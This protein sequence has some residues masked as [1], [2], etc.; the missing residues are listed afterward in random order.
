MRARVLLPLILSCFLSMAALRLRAQEKPLTVGPAVLTFPQIAA[1]LAAP[2]RAI[3]CATALRQRAAFVRLHDRDWSTARRLLESALDVRFREKPEAKGVWLLEADPEVTEREKVWRDRL[4]TIL[5]E[6]M[7][8]KTERVA[9]LLRTPYHV[10]FQR[11]LQLS[12]EIEAREKQNRDTNDPQI[13]QLKAEAERLQEFAMPTA[14]VNAVTLRNT[15]QPDV[16]RV[17]DTP[18]GYSP[19][20]ARRFMD[21]S[22]VVRTLD[23]ALEHEEA[24]RQ[25][26]ARRQEAETG[27]VQVSGF[28]EGFNRQFREILKEV[29]GGNYSVWR[30][31]RFDPQTV[32]LMSQLQM[33]VGT[34][35]LINDD[36]TVSPWEE[37]GVESVFDTLGA[38]AK[39]WHAGERAATETFLKRDRAKRLFSVN[40]KGF[41]NALSQAVEAWQKADGGDV[42]MELVPLREEIALPTEEPSEEAE[43]NQPPPR[44]TSLKEI[45]ADAHLPMHRTWSFREQD[46]VLLVK[47]DL[48]FVN[49]TQTYPLSAFLALERRWPAQA[50]ILRL[51]DLH[52]YHQSVNAS[53]N[54][55]LSGLNIYRG[56]P[57]GLVAQS[58]PFVLLLDR[59]SPMER[60]KLM[61]APSPAVEIPLISFGKQPLLEVA[62]AL[63]E[64]RLDANSGPEEALLPGFADILATC[65]LRIEKAPDES[66]VLNL[67]LSLMR[68][69]AGKMIS[70][71]T[72]ADLI[73]GDLR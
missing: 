34:E 14:F 6:K 71:K 35:S 54:A 36:Q 41:M 57:I 11:Y 65:L 51:A 26:E 21:V 45:M 47:N 13:K 24:V 60:A 70:E 52:S 25:A 20:D 58:R 3:E 32:A 38:E 37:K 22:K 62:Q 8:V 46:K 56:L 17:L 59:L 40:R 5:H 49:R 48:A 44:D 42:I 7:L 9:P 61:Q 33:F 1:R 15:R 68:P 23:A 63:R 66:G 28:A 50:S 12:L 73:L 18:T 29:D 4:A 10:F 69:A 72:Y 64:I 19:I 30:R 43:T 16:R 67:H 2:G 31:L 27:E 55:A 53:Q 39:Q